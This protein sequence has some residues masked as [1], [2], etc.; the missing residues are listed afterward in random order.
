MPPFS[1]NFLARKSLSSLL[2]KTFEAKIQSTFLLN[3]SSYAPKN[4]IEAKIRKLTFFGNFQTQCFYAFLEW[5]EALWSQKQ[6]F[7]N[8]VVEVPIPFP[9]VHSVLASSLVVWS[10]QDDLSKK[11][12]VVCELSIYLKSAKKCF[13]LLRDKSSASAGRPS[14]ANFHPLFW[15][16][17]LCSSFAATAFYITAERRSREGRRRRAVSE[18]Y[19]SVPISAQ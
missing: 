13:P 10:W 16:R 8:S 11:S 1:C 19:F 2:C 18:A 3:K 17:P 14:D 4:Y 6:S 15:Q 9:K 12:R 5:I 7:K